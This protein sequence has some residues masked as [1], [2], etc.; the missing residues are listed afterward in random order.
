MS[1]TSSNR[2]L[3][4]GEPLYGLPTRYEGCPWGIAP[5]STLVVHRESNPNTSARD[6][7][8]VIPQPD[9]QFRISPIPRVP[10]HRIEYWLTNIRSDPN[11]FALGAQ[12]RRDVGLDGLVA[13][14]DGWGLVIPDEPPNAAWAERYG[15][16]WEVAWVLLATA[17]RFLQPWRRWL[18]D[19]AA[20]TAAEMA[21][22]EGLTAAV[23]V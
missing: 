2:L 13:L 15:A 12:L 7:L 20:Y 21:F 4:D 10:Y 11:W 9:G 16:D 3:D 14:I 6:A 19:D 5:G 23:C 18:S 22:L 17:A 1:V 8:W